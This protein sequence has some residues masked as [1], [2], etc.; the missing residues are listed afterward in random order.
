MVGWEEVKDKEYKKSELHEIYVIEFSSLLL[1]DVGVATTP[2]R[3]ISVSNTYVPNCL[4]I[5]V[6]NTFTMIVIVTL[7]QSYQRE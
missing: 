3:V 4:L 1:L 2:N 6:I 7:G 5:H